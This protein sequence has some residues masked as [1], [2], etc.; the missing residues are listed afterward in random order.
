MRSDAKENRQRILTVATNL[1]KKQDFKNITM[2]Q[3][4]KEA[5]VGIGTLYRNF[6]TKN[7]LYLTILYEKL[8]KYAKKESAYLDVHPINLTAIKRVLADYLNFREERLNLFP[9]VTFEA[10][11]RYYTHD[12]YQELVDLFARIFMSYKKLNRSSA[13]FQADTLAAALRSDAYYYQRKGRGLSQEQILQGLLKL[14]F[15]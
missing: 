1:L 5:H 11:T 13:L 4:A 2:A 6:A 12:N 8:D 15:E 7:E 3:V 14:F 10:A 9:P